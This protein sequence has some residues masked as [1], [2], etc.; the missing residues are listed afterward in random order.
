METKYPK[1]FFFVAQIDGKFWGELCLEVARYCGSIRAEGEIPLGWLR[2][3]PQTNQSV[4]HRASEENGKESLEL[5]L[6]HPRN[7]T[8]RWPKH[9]HFFNG[10]ST[11]SKAHHFGALQPLVFESV[12]FPHFF[13]ENG[14]WNP[15]DTWK[16]FWR[17][18]E[19]VFNPS[20]FSSSAV[21]F[22]L[23]LIV[24]LTEEIRRAPPGM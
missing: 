20:F 22:L 3:Y 11:F 9:C 21:S 14:T 8:A 24:L 12:H 18:M 5:K 6:I 1:A 2:L 10:S 4:T 23:K 13:F 7:L 17:W 19:V 16:N 15:R